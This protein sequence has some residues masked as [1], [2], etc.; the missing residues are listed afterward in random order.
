MEAPYIHVDTRDACPQS[1]LESYH[2]KPGKFPELCI[3]SANQ[4]QLII[5]WQKEVTEDLETT[6]LS[7]SSLFPG[8]T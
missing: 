8:R 3:I 4:S 7:F 2:Q 5:D 6:A 1:K